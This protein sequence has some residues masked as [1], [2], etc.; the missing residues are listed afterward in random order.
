MALPLQANAVETV[1]NHP[2]QVL[3]GDTHL[4]TS[5]SSDAFLFG[6][7]RLTPEQAYRFARGETVSASNGKSARLRQPLDFIVI[8]D[9]AE[10][11]GMMAYID[12]GDPVVMS[13]PNAE[14]W[15]ARLAEIG[16]ETGAFMH[17]FAELG[18]PEMKDPKA[19]NTIW[20]D[21]VALADAANTPGVFTAL[22]GFEWSSTPGGNNLHRVVVFRDGAGMADQVLPF[23]EFNSPHPEDLWVYLRDYHERIGGEVLA[24][25]HNS[26]ASNGLMFP[27]AMRDGRRI[28][29]AYADARRHWEPLIEVTQIKGDSESHP[30]L[31]P[32][33]EFAGYSVWDKG[34]L[35]V[36]QK[37]TPAMLAH[38]Y[39]RPALRLGLELA[40]Q[41]GS[42]PYQFG[43]IGG[44]DSHTS[45]STAD[46]DNFW[47]GTPDNEPGPG[48]MDRVLIPSSIDH[49]MDIM[50]WEQE[51][52]GYAAVWA[53][54]NTRNEI[55]DAM[56]RREV[57]A[58]TGPRI[59]LRFFGGW[60][61]GEEDHLKPNF[62]D[63][64]YELGVPM[65]SELRRPIGNTAPTFMVAALKDPNGANLDRVQIIKGWQDKAGASHERV[66]DVAWPGHR[67]TSVNGRLSE[68]G[69]TVEMSTATYTNAIGV[70][71][72]ATV[73]TDPEFDPQARAFYYVRVLEIP[74]PRWVLYDAVRFG[75]TVPKGARTVHQE[76][77]YSS[78]IW[79]SP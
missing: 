52:S 32:D 73:W 62:V 54:D 31:S 76:R 47:G 37:K 36:S 30:M 69:S 33:D 25:S 18:N 8:A 63:L 41:T 3:W 14:R 20:R 4:H 55:F 75:A 39:A 6:N 68:V 79:Y 43:M 27:A 9:H 61:F 15:R 42:N 50:S 10:N 58:S 12:A 1:H 44:T 38:E 13:T 2:S 51:A 48:R 56:Q 16:S 23:A 70:S 29:K 46:D 17:I 5:W 57:Y 49:N 78:P 21:Y 60:K 59:T 28:D 45:L 11:L 66:Y 26:N 40:Q 24:I 74:T 77:A 64:G 53:R 35:L 19:R 34:N 7:K 67:K 71:Q 65:G 22:V 72:L